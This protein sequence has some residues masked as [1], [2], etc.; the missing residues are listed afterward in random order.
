MLKN[1]EK[2]DM[3]ILNLLVNQ[4]RFNVYFTVIEMS[5]RHIIQTI[6]PTNTIKST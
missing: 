1:V 6:T 5:Q 3:I 4:M 2:E